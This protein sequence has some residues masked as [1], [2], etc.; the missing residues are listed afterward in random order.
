MGPRRGPRVYLT[1]LLLGYSNVSAER[2]QGLDCLKASTRLWLCVSS[3]GKFPVYGVKTNRGRG[4][5][6]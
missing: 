6:G 2:A 4:C 3:Q 5:A 1:F